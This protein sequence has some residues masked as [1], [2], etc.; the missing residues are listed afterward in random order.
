MVV[1]ITGTSKGIGKGLAAHLAAQG[2][3]VHGCSRSPASL[4]HPN[5]QHTTIDVTKAGEVK[6]F[7]RGIR[8]QSGS[9]DALI[10]NA[11]T[12]VMN[13]FMLTPEETT[14]A[15]FDLNVHGALLCCREAVKLMLSSPGPWPCI[16]NVSSVAV[17]WALAGQLAYSA[18]KVA[19]EQVTRVLS[20]ELGPHNIRVNAIGLPPLRTAL[21]RTVPREKIDALIARQALPRPCEMEDVVGPIDFLLSDRARFVTGEVLYLGGVYG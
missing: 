14:R 15:L 18:S 13:H 4:C 7:F 10:N 1:A 16:L 17:P 11:G 20:K 9:L 2:H 19:I 5:Y 3:Q 8:Q 12:A 21:T 6:R